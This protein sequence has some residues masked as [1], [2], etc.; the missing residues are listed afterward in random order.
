[1]LVIEMTS[2]FE[3]RR[4]DIMESTTLVLNAFRT[5]EQPK[6]NS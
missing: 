2:F 1:V 3:E 5:K 6:I 4:K